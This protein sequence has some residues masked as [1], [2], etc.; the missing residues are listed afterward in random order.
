[1]NR[2]KSC[3]RLVGIKEHKC[4]PA[5][6]KGLKGCY[7][8][9]K[10]TKDRIGAKLLGRRHHTEET[11]QRLSEKNK[12]NKY[13]LGKKHSE[14][15]RRK[16][17][18]SNKGKIINPEAI[19]KTRQKLL[20]RKLSEEQRAKRRGQY[21][22][23]WKGGISC[24]NFRIRASAEYITWRSKVYFRDKYTCVLCSHNAKTKKNIRLNADHIKAFSILLKENNI[25]S[26][27]DA[28]NCKNL[29]NVENG[30]T[31]CFDCH[32]QTD[33]YAGR[34]NKFDINKQL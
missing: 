9:S 28:I 22:S 13:N 23:N 34:A 16:I 15:T 30:R 17:S 7:S 3:G 20:G 27:L 14:E 31:L 8:L 11:K 10:E 33:N 4:K 19:E 12:G 21:A 6:N 1:M 18:E 26:T 29:W 32:K 2:C 24:L 5:W 25:K